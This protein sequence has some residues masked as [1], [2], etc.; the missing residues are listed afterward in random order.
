MM[1]ALQKQGPPE[2]GAEGSPV[3]RKCLRTRALHW[4]KNYLYQKFSFTSRRIV[5]GEVKKWSG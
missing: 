1:R 3:F 5:Q 4:V 2:A